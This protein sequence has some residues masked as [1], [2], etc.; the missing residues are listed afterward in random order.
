MP[1]DNEND[2]QVKKDQIESQII[3]PPSGLAEDILGKI[4]E[5]S[6]QNQINTQTENEKAADENSIK[7]V[8][9]FLGK[10]EY[11]LPISKVQEINRIVD[12]T[13]VP[14]SPQHIRGVINLR[15]KI[16]PVIELKSRLNLGQ[17]TIQK[18]SRIVVIEHSSKI[19][20]LMV[21]QVAQVQ[22]ISE[23]QIEDAPDEVIKIDENYINGV[24]KLDQRMVI[25]LD[26]EK[27]ISGC[28]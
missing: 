17:T 24:G 15:G 3:L 7:F 25:L 19:L 9:F 20:G 27:V 18:Q 23:E 2:N 6:E 14:N 28:N 5:Q 10:E 22:N 13:R 12:I 4:S 8:T 16:L 11:G 1:Q 21:D 26:L